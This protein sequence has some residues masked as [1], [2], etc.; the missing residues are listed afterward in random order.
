MKILILLLS[1]MVNVHSPVQLTEQKSCE[2]W[3]WF[4]KWH[5]LQNDGSVLSIGED[6]TDKVLIIQ[7]YA[8]F[9]LNGSFVLNFWF[10]GKVTGGIVINGKTFCFPLLFFYLFVRST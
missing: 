2:S 3:S 10:N 8:P 5:N 7:G 9:N 4:S 1:V 6:C